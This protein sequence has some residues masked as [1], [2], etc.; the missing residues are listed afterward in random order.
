MVT[1]PILL[2]ANIDLKEAVENVELSND[3]I[4]CRKRFINYLMKSK[5]NELQNKF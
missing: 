2:F 3:N 4:L 5:A 1:N